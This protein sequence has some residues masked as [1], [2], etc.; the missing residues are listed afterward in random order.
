MSPP[1]CS[2]RKGRLATNPFR[3]CTARGRRSAASLPYVANQMP[4]FQPAEARQTE[5]LGL[6]SAR[7]LYPHASVVVRHTAGGI[8]DAP[9]DNDVSLGPMDLEIAARNRREENSAGETAHV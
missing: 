3:A 2:G 8:D 4:D 1:A 7:L 6:T 5:S 9:A